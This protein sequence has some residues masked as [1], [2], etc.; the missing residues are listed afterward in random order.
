MLKNKRILGKYVDSLRAV[1]YPFNYLNILNSMVDDVFLPD[2]VRGYEN[3]LLSAISSAVIEN[4][5]VLLKFKE[6]A[7]D[8]NRFTAGTYDEMP[9][10]SFEDLTEEF[11]GLLKKYSGE[12]VDQRKDVV[13]MNDA[14]TNLRAFCIHEGFDF[15]TEIYE[16]ANDIDETDESRRP[17]LGIE[18]IEDGVLTSVVNDRYDEVRKTIG[19]Y[20]TTLCKD[21]EK[22]RLLM[23]DKEEF[24]RYFINLDTRKK[25]MIRRKTVAVL[26]NVSEKNDD[27]MFTTE[28]IVQVINGR[29]KKEVPY[30]SVAF[31][32]NKTEL[33]L[34]R[35]YSNPHV[36]MDQLIEIVMKLRSMPFSEV[37]DKR[38]GFMKPSSEFR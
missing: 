28:G 25:R 34:H 12:Y 37:K 30:D 8:T 5:D 10:F 17:Y 16:K 9:E 26:D 20:E 14:E 2:C 7:E 29:V 33:I 3:L 21:P 11:F 32:S 18:L 36:N 31:N 22:A 15:P 27:L 1:D 24:D 13:S 19:E 6:K 4:R 38:R 23:T 35:F